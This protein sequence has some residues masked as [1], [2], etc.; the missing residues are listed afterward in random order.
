M[1]LGL[2]RRRRRVAGVG[3]AV[4][5]LCAGL[6]LYPV[7]AFPS[8][9][10]FDIVS[11]NGRKFASPRPTFGVAR[12]EAFP[13][14]IRTWPIE[15]SAGGSAGC[16]LWSSQILLMAGGLIV[17]G[18]GY[19]T[20]MACEHRIMETERAFDLALSWALFWWP[21]GAD[22]IL[23]GFGGVMRLTPSVSISSR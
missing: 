4:L 20:A 13:L 10:Q 1:S 15:I 21:D 3:L 9:Q 6:I 2:E 7:I 12:G 22:I 16:N 18:G 19:R 5:A 23:V 11:I 8:H 17:L 14:G